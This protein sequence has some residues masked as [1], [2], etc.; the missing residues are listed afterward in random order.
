MSTLLIRES[1]PIL[2]AAI[3]RPESLNAIDFDIMAQLEKTLSRL[4][5]PGRWKVFILRAEGGRYFASGGDIRKFARL[6]SREEGLE[7]AQRMEAIL[8]RI[9]KLSCWT[10]VSVDG[11]AYGGGC[12][13][14]L[15][16]D[17]IIAS[18]KARFGFT[19]SRFHLPPGWGGLTRLIE[20]VGRSTALEWLGEATVRDAPEALRKGL[21]NRVVPDGDLK[22]YTMD[23]A[24]RLSA[25][26]PDLI[27]SL[28]N[29]ARFS[30]QNDRLT[31]I[32]AEQSVFAEFWA[33]EEHHRRVSSFLKKKD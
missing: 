16:F 19:Q 13:I 32:R 23:L 20:R 33:G 8:E 4:E 21:L 28:K 7:M 3:N 14:L 5:E 29:S 18:E 27:H 22:D 1:E 9:E 10:M 24:E 11:D 12:E 31:A 17:F 15:A 30:L 25:T 26:E 2:I 6:K